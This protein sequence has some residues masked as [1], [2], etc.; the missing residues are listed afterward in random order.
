VH[1]ACGGSSSDHHWL[2]LVDMV[3]PG[4]YWVEY[5]NEND[6]KCASE[7][8]TYIAGWNRD[9]PWLKAAHPRASFIGPVTLEYKGQYIQ[10]FMQQAVP[11]PDA[12]SWHEYVCDIGHTDQYCLE[13]ITRWANHAVDMYARM[14]LAGYHVPVWI[15][16][17]N[18]N[19][20]DDTR[21]HTGFI[22][23]WTARALDEWAMLERAGVVDVTMLYTMT[24]HAN[25]GLV[26][27]DG[28]FT[29]QGRMFF[30]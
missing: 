12:V 22:E 8:A 4:R 16:E 20:H 23:L 11:R 15:T 19:P 14:T 18:M 10:T 28:S 29:A 30:G 24:D 9:V 6:M 7:A 26:K 21:Y 17:W 27:P 1:G 25:S 5:G 13:H 2:D 3:F